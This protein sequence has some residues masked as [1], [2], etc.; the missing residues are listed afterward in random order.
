[1]CA[2]NDGRLVNEPEPEP[3]GCA[4]RDWT[5]TDDVPKD[6]RTMFDVVRGY[7]WAVTVDGEWIDIDTSSVLRRQHV[8]CIIRNEYLRLWPQRR[9][10]LANN[11]A[12]VF[13]AEVERGVKLFVRSGQGKQRLTLELEDELPN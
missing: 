7:D 5:L 13:M 10:K 1:M 2:E 11:A 4:L 9:G 3:D 8:A 12:P 6:F